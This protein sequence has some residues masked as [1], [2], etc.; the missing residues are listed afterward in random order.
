VPT[1]LGLKRLAAA[2]HCLLNLLHHGEGVV[3]TSEASTSLHAAF[4][5]SFCLCHL[6]TCRHH[7]VESTHALLVE[8]NEIKG[9]KSV[10]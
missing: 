3:N 2:L 6:V 5:H 1:A 4:L 8:D 10:I 7:C 9:M